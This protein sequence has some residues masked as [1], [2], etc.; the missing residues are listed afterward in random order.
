MNKKLILMFNMLIEYLWYYKN[1][2][3][4]INCIVKKYKIKRKKQKLNFFL[5]EIKYYLYIKIRKIKNLI[6]LIKI[7]IKMIYYH[8]IILKY[9]ILIRKYFEK[10]KA[11]KQNWYNMLVTSLLIAQLLL[12]NLEKF[13]NIKV[14]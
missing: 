2:E 8:L 13:H 5:I 7:T 6:E 11:I 12:V 10:F 9:I 14:V 4:N 1:F 3:G